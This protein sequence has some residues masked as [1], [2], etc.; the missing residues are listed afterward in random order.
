MLVL[1]SVRWF[2]LSAIVLMLLGVPATAQ[3]PVSPTGKVSVCK[4]I[5]DDWKCVGESAEWAANTNFNVLFVNSVPVGVDF[6]GIVIHKVG[7]DGKD[8]DFI[9]EY[10]QNIGEEN[11]KYATVGDNFRLPSGT[12][13]IYIITWGNR[14]TMIHNGNFKEY[15]AK[16]ILKVK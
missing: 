2:V 12:Y 16:T 15:L 1:R 9:N 14:E 7:A 8:I 10:Q 6:I 5:D 11:R 3:K 13:S 4:E